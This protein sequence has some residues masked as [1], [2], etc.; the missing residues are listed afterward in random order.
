MFAKLRAAFREAVENFKTEL[1]R[2][3]IPETVDGLLAGMYREATDA[4]A[5]VSKLEKDLAAARARAQRES[6]QAEVCRRRQQ[7]AERI[8][9]EETVRV[10]EE[11]ARKHEERAQVIEGKAEAI[12]RE[13]TVC[14]SD[15]DEML[16]QIK[17]ARQKSEALGATAGRT[18]ARET[19]GRADDLFRDFD[20]MG[21]KVSGTESEAEAAA[22]FDREFEPGP[23][24]EENLEDR[25]EELK[26]RMG[27]R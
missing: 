10:A 21:E 25:L 12:L 2:D 1:N 20:R 4:K 26:R 9:D 22:A 15:V 6:E 18:E 16:E 19:L 8:G 5:Y 27:K 11:F 3:Q 17:V 14:R 24:R 13:L 7:Q 23:S